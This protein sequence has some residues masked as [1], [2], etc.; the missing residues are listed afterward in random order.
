MAL[1]SARQHAVG[2][3]GPAHSPVRIHQRCDE[4]D[5]GGHGRAGLQRRAAQQ[6]IEDAAR[7]HGEFSGNIDK[8][9]VRRHAARRSDRSG[10]FHDLSV[11]AQAA[12]RV[13]GV[14]HQAIAA[15]LVARE[16]LGLHQHHLSAGLR[17]QSGA[18][19]ASRACADH[20]HIATFSQRRQR[21]V[22]VCAAHLES[23]LEAVSSLASSKRLAS[24][25]KQGLRRAPVKISL[26]LDDR[27]A[28]R[29][30]QQNRAP[31][32]PAPNCCQ[33]FSPP[34]M[35]RIIN[36]LWNTL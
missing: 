19:T 4:S 36:R 24:A 30:A 35:P 22:P 27:V 12:Q 8:A 10:Q 23:F 6:G 32:I 1:G 34:T 2:Q 21:L 31:Q 11:H 17:Q 15:N 18:G 33:S 16:A 3:R 13:V 9:A 20:Q 28:D 25:M 26:S 5:W 29:L 14:W 7:Q